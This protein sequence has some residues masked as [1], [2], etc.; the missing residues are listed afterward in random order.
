ML[1]GMAGIPTKEGTFL[2]YFGRVSTDQVAGFTSSAL[3]PVSRAIAAPYIKDMF[4]QIQAKA[5]QQ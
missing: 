4:K 3:H 2:F 1:Q 5:K